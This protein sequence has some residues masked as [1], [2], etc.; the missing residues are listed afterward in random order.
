MNVQELIE[1][2]QDA[3][4]TAEVRIATQP[5]YPLA[6]NLY[7]VAVADESEPHLVCGGCGTLVELRE[8][9]A[10]HVA[11]WRDDD[12]EPFPSEYDDDDDDSNA[13]EPGVAWLVAGDHPRDASPY[14]PRA[15][16]DSA[17][18]W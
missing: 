4:P 7:G 8:G 11:S 5:S 2:L 1:L 14:A 17:R 10:H 13:L 15:A 3:D 12:H 18:R 9:E 16:W 6:F